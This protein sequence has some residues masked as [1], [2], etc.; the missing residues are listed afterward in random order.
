MSISSQRVRGPLI[1]IDFLRQPAQVLEQRR[2]CGPLP[3]VAEFFGQADLHLSP[4]AQEQ[5]VDQ[6]PEADDAGRHGR[7]DYDRRR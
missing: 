2:A 1:R 4:I 3:E 7:P 5:F 6:Q